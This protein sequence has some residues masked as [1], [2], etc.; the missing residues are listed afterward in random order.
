MTLELKSLF[1]GSVAL[2]AIF[3]S[4]GCGDTATSSD[5]VD[6]SFVES[7]TESSATL[8]VAA[9]A[10]SLGEGPPGGRRGQGPPEEALA[11]CAETSVGEACSFIGP[12]GESH[13]GTCTVRPDDSEQVVCRPDNWPGREGRDRRGPP[14][15]ALAACSGAASGDECSFEAPF[16]SVSG[17]CVMPPNGDALAC[18]PSERRR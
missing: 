12:R 17:A 14:E 1:V 7:A 6:T 4:F 15:E 11:A 9:S 3:L 16:G 10:S 5:A 18:R 13:D 8:A 2:A